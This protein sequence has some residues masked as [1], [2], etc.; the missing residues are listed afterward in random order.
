MF[1]NKPS[2]FK[3]SGNLQYSKYTLVNQLIEKITGLSRLDQLYQ[4]LP[5]SNTP[6]EFLNQVFDLF[7]ITYQ[8]QPEELLHIPKEGRR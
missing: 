4:A 2:P 1:S 5:I 6:E 3:L 8:S 7:K